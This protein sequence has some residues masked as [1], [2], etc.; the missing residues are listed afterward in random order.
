M[1]VLVSALFKVEAAFYLKNCG[2]RC[3]NSMSNEHI[4]K[5]AKIMSTAP[6]N[7]GGR[8]DFKKAKVK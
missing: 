3:T 5:E 7:K 4:Q 1:Q 8:C 6:D 2:R